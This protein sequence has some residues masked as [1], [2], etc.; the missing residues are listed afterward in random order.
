MSESSKYYRLKGTVFVVRVPPK[1]VSYL[2]F[3]YFCVSEQNVKKKRLFPFFFFVLFWFI[4]VVISTHPAAVVRRT[5]RFDCCILSEVSQ[6]VFLFL[7]FLTHWFETRGRVE[8][9]SIRR[10]LSRQNQSWKWVTTPRSVVILL[11]L[12][13]W[14]FSVQHRKTGKETGGSNNEQQQQQEKKRS[15]RSFFLLLFSR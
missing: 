10:V 7:F 1:M 13:T 14:D 3:L 9:S 11:W 6:F 2:F 15:S 5:H 12:W 4:I 8:C